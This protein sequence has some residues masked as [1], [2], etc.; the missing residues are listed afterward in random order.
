MKLFIKNTMIQTWEIKYMK[1]EYM[2]NNK[3][4]K[5]TIIYKKI[6]EKI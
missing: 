6:Y 4:I 3:S 5:F 2:V 1:K